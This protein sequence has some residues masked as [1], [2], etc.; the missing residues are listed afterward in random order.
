MSEKTKKDLR[1]IAVEGVIGAGK[2]SLA[3]KLTERLNAQLVLE[4]FEENPFLEKFYL[5]RK[6]YA[7][8]TQMFFLI[9][10]YKQQQELMQG[11]LFTDYLVADY[12]FEKDK[13]FAYLNLDKDELQ[14]YESIFPLLQKTLVK[15][16]LVIFLHSHVDRL[17]Y[18]IKKR[19]RLIEKGIAKNYI[20]ELSESYANYF[21]SYNGSPILIVDSSEIDFVGQKKD[22]EELFSAI[23]RADRAPVEY[24]RPESRNLF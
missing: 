6:R 17:M 14:L 13:I 8:Q 16:D 7:F 5:D 19:N 20:Q 24:F 21:F 23:F 3:K 4:K 2:T 11:N 9:N 10:R 22:F 18:N 1:Y 15:P 12:I